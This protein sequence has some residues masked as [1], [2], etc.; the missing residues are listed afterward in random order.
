MSSTIEADAAFS[1]HA[2]SSF[3]AGFSPSAARADE[4]RLLVPF[5]VE[6][7]WD[8]AVVQ[9]RQPGGLGGELSVEV[10]NGNDTPR[11]RSQIE[12]VLQA[13]VDTTPFDGVCDADPVLAVV[14]SEHPL[15]RPVLFPSVFEALAWSILS[16]RTTMAAASN[17]ARRLAET[18]GTRHELDDGTSIHVFPTPRQ[19]ADV[20]PM[21][22]VNET[23]AERLRGLAEAVVDDELS[24][25]RLLTLDPDDAA[26]ELMRL[27]GIGPFSA[28]LALVRGVGARDVLPVHEGRLEAI[29]Q[30]LYDRPLTEV[31]EAWRPWRAWA[32]FLLRVAVGS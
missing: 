24:A 16:Q 4:K 23:R 11:L 9:V 2:A 27:D 7:E 15:L 19:L 1:L 3:L 25:P 13:A 8:P 17:A 30:D 22:G 20:Q 14:R 6:G 28:E 12:R 29:V 26:E 10:L 21:K 5:V 18:I 32:A 31:A